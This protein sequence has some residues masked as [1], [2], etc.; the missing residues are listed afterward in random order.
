MTARAATPRFPQKEAEEDPCA[1]CDCDECTCQEDDECYDCCK[2]S[3][4]CYKKLVKYVVV[5]KVEECKCCTSRVALFGTCHNF[6][7]CI[8]VYRI[9]TIFEMLLY[10][11]G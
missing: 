7:S 4:A 8:A 10:R 1:D 9:Q 11:T 5:K 6:D 3:D 2:D